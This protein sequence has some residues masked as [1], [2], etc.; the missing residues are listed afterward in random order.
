MGKAVEEESAKV[1][2]EERS[3]SPIFYADLKNWNSIEFVYGIFQLTNKALNTFAECI[4]CG[5]GWAVG[6]RTPSATTSFD[7]FFDK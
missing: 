6:I 3:L 1:I 7:H 2:T 5:N 4:L